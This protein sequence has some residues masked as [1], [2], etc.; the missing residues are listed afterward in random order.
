[1]TCE[2][3]LKNKPPI[4]SFDGII[5]FCKKCRNKGIRS[6][7]PKIKK[8]DV[9]VKKCEICK[10]ETNIIYDGFML[11]GEEF[12]FE[13]EERCKECTEQIKHKTLIEGEDFAPTQEKNWLL[14]F[15]L[16]KKLYL[17][18]DQKKSDILFKKIQKLQLGGKQNE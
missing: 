16:Y 7:D 6:S 11:L 9:L 14:I 3:C 12:E 15:K 10:R 13:D 8:K 4:Y 2:I 17:E 1:M 5:W 18:T